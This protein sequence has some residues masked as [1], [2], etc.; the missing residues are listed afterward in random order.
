MPLLLR[1]MAGN[2]SHVI[3]TRSCQHSLVGRQL[4]S[5]ASQINT[6]ANS[7]FKQFRALSQTEH[8]V[9]DELVFESNALFQKFFGSLFA[10]FQSGTLCDVTILVGTLSIPC[11]RIVLACVSDYFKTMF[12]L[13]MAESHEKEILIRDINPH[14]LQQLIEFAYTGRVVITVDTVQ[15]L[16][17]ASLILN[18]ES[19]AGVCC[20]FMTSHLHPLNC[21][22]V[23]AFAAMHARTD[24][25]DKADRFAIEH[26]SAVVEGEEFETATLNNLEVLLASPDL[27]VPSEVAVYEAVLKWIKH[28]TEGKRHHLP[29]LLMKVRMP[30]LPITYLVDVVSKEELIRC[31]LQCRDIV[32]DAKHYQLSVAHIATDLKSLHFILPRKSYAGKQLILLAN[33]S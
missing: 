27:N 4:V 32:D 15:Q 6:D 21:I 24:L 31:N 11:H 14:C 26:F 12:T 8:M 19:V 33:D 3:R 25:M 9:D 28:D 10:F 1:N 23:R 13:D 16:L 2:D 20:D 29:A 17:Y 30:L 22:G 7:D 18:I 5:S